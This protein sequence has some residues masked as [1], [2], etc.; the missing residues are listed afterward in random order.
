MDTKCE[1]LAIDVLVKYINPVMAIGPMGTSYH[2]AT[3]GAANRM[4]QLSSEL[5]WSAIGGST[6]NLNFVLL[7]T[8]HATMGG[9]TIQGK[10]ALHVIGPTHP[11]CG[12]VG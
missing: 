11:G 6:G 1:P 12:D 7:T 3:N 8:P 4:V 5:L 2:P 9:A 10:K